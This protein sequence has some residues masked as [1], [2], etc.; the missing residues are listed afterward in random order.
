MQLSVS[1]QG[2]AAARGGIPGDLIVLIEEMEH[3]LLK[4]NG[5]NLYYDH[6]IN[7]ADAA[8]GITIEVPTIDGKASVKVD[9]GTQSGNILRLKGKGLPR[10]NQYGKGDILVN[11]SVW[12]PQNLTSEADNIN[13]LNL[14][15]KSKSKIE[16]CPIKEQNLIYYGT[17]S[18]CGFFVHSEHKLNPYSF[19]LKILPSFLK[20]F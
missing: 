1:G 13:T 16:S 19:T 3:E 9:A 7:I 4:R 10:L 8:M 14:L 15:F 17:L 11:I 12:T 18:L 6:Y 5:S 2:N 20:A